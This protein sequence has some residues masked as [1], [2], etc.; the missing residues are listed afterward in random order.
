MSLEPPEEDTEDTALL[1]LTALTWTRKGWT[2]WILVSLA[3]SL[4]LICFG[5]GTKLKAGRQEAWL[6]NCFTMFWFSH[7]Q[8]QC[9]FKSD[10]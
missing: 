5:Q 4:T 7:L 3:T 9:G 2:A 10:F 1:G 6:Q 8:L